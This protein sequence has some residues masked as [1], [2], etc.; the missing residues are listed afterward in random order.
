MDVNPSGR[1]EGGVGSWQSCQGPETGKVVTE[2]ASTPD[3]GWWGVGPI[4]DLGT[5]PPHPHHQAG[6]LTDGKD[7]WGVE[8]NRGFAVALTKNSQLTHVDQVRSLL[9]WHVQLPAEVLA[10]AVQGLQRD[11]EGPGW[12]PGEI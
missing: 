4:T 12:Q 7:P 5:G 3:T 1:A 8:L 11:W 2:G 10:G 6:V 9:P